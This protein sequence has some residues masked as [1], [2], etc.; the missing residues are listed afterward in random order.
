VFAYAAKHGYTELLDVSAPLT[1]RSDFEEIQEA[2]NLETYIV[3]VS[4]APSSIA[5]YTEVTARQDISRSG[6]IS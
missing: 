2:V 3:W 6:G 4:L 5:V 1:L